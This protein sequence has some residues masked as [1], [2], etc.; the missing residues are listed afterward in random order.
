MITQGKLTP[1]FS[2]QGVGAFYENIESIPVA[3]FDWIF[4][5]N[6]CGPLLL[7]QA[8]LPYLASPG[9]QI[10]SISSVVA[11]NGTIHGNL[12]SATKGA[13]NSMSLGWAEQLGPK[14]I[15]VNIISPSPIETDMVMPESHLLTQKFRVEQY[16]KRNGTPGEVA[17]TVQF[18]ASP[19]A[20][21]ITGQNIYVDG[22]L[23][24]T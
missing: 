10:V 16:I 18:L 15:T 1:W 11:K 5:T 23:I 24:Y 7:V 14:G 22:G 13:L 6:V 17:E 4:H 3:D 12:Y 8:A 2:T 9:G 21:F 19:G 20:S